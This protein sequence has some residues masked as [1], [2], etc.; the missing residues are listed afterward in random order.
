MLNLKE[1][2]DWKKG[3]KF[4]SAT[5]IQIFCFFLL[6]VN[7]NLNGM[8][9]Y[10][11]VS[12]FQAD[13][14]RIP[15]EHSFTDEYFNFGDTN[16][17]AFSDLDFERNKF[18]PIEFS[19]IDNMDMEDQFSTGQQQP[20]Q[21]KPISMQQQYDILFEFKSSI[22]S[23]VIGGSDFFSKV[24]DYANKLQM[25]KFKSIPKINDK[26][27][28]KNNHSARIK[29]D[30]QHKFMIS[31]LESWDVHLKSIRTHFMQKIFNKLWKVPTQQILKAHCFSGNNSQ[32]NKIHIIV[33]LQNEMEQIEIQY[34]DFQLKQEIYQNIIQR[35]IFCLDLAIQLNNQADDLI[36]DVLFKGFIA[37]LFHY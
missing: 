4:D 3:K 13:Q 10:S 25:N 9:Q 35:M 17:F 15:E 2:Q 8:T 20:Q 31:K 32:Q 36:F 22:N 16:N 24:L 33:Y 34:S 6:L 7:Q 28:K 19:F 26:T 21:L 11:E 1:I 5:L 37:E 14:F 29:G 18:L 12:I 23:K 30:K 27:Q